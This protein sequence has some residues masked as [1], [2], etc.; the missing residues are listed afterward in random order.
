MVGLSVLFAATIITSD[1]RSK[2]KDFD[3]RT[4]WFKNYR[5]SRGK[6]LPNEEQKHNDDI[7]LSLVSKD[8]LLKILQCMLDENEFLSPGGIRSLSKYHEK[9]PLAYHLNGQ[10]LHIQYD[11]ADSTSNMFGGNSNWRGPVWMPVNYLLIKSLRKYHRFYGDEVKL[12][13][14]TG[15]GIMMN[16][17]EVADEIV[18]RLINIFNVDENG[19]RPVHGRSTFYDRPENKDLI[20]FY[21]YFHGETS[22]GLGASH[23]TGWTSLIAELINDDVW[24]WET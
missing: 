2:L 9:N 11:P 18:K 6:Y 15:S 24:E 14:P 3:R 7:L 23:Q 12:E 20:L 21:E 4:T 16:L 19:K 5:K 8:K 13:C 1:T 22:R 17:A 10:H